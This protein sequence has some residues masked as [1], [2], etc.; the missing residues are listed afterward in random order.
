MFLLATIL[1]TTAAFAGVLSCGLVNF[2]DP[3]YLTK[4]N[5]VQ[6]GI[7]AKSVYVAFTE[8]RHSNW[9]PLTWLSLMVDFEIFKTNPVGY[10]L[11][12]LLLHL[13]STAFLFLFLSR[14]TNTHYRAAFATLLFAVH[15]LR[16][17]SVAWVAE[18]KDV[19]SVALGLLALL[20]YERYARLNKRRYYYFALTA[21][22]ASLMS[23][24]TLVT[25]PCLLLLIDF[26]P[27]KRLS[28][29]KIWPLIAEKLPFA[30]LSI[31]I[32]IISIMA[33]ASG[34]SIKSETDTIAGPSSRA[35]YAI[36]AYLQ[37]TFWP[38][39]L[40][41]FYPFPNAGISGIEV[42]VGAAIISVI[43]L[44][45][46]VNLR[47]HPHIFV[48][49][50]WFLGTLVPMLGIIQVGDQA[51]ADRYTYFPHIGL[52]ILVSWSGAEILFKIRDKSN[53]S[54]THAVAAA[55]ALIVG[56]LAAA[57]NKQVQT[58]QDSETLWKHALDVAPDNFK[59]RNNLGIWYLDN[60]QYAQALEQ[61][62][63][64]DS[65]PKSP[66]NGYANLGLT[67][68]RLGRCDEA[69]AQLR[70][71]DSLSP[72]TAYI[73]QR[74]ARAFE[75]NGNLNEARHYLEVTAALDNLRGEH[76]F[77]LG[78]VLTKLNLAEDAE[79]MIA[80]AQE[81]DPD[82][83]QRTFGY[84]WH[85]ATSTELNPRD[86]LEAV[87]HAELLHC[88]DSKDAQVIDLVA[89]AHADAGDFEKAEKFVL[90]AIARA[91]ADSEFNSLLQP[92]RRHLELFQQKIPLRITAGGESRLQ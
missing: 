83:R 26:W 78:C 43:S 10:H 16:V 54:F 48:G 55:A 59:A 73:T 45:A 66:A 89:A 39:D 56:G 74:L 82:W 52:A 21:F 90:E 69:I 84:A 29:G 72:K 20:T 64:V 34:N 40:A 37:K 13:L 49:W 1:V 79:M 67:L 4:S 9:H 81:K 19:L 42:L 35:V 92:L 17:E 58:W 41:V 77:S 86:P 25:M 75:C 38:K 31:G 27:L 76:L 70:K 85:L 88:V 53:R 24:S 3:V 87:Y 91:K 51:Y 28:W 32:S 36:T 22:A 5:L 11:T 2:D 47:R 57:T 71:A 60:R 30:M 6:S 50:G 61:L 33:Q 8:F 65:F 12:N 63:R 46:L 44:L 18:R 68:I 7:T 62:I 15:P 23:K 80:A 14:A